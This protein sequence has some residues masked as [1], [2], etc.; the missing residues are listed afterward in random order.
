MVKLQVLRRFAKVFGGSKLSSA[1]R[2]WPQ[3]RHHLCACV[4]VAESCLTLWNPMNSSPPGSSVFGISQA[5]ILECVANPFSRGSSRPRDWT[6]VSCIAGRVFTVWATREAPT[7]PLLPHNNPHKTKPF[8]MPSY[9]K[10]D[11]SS[12]PPW[13]FR[14]LSPKQEGKPTGAVAFHCTG[15]ICRPNWVTNYRK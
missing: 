9:S 3:R 7:A 1:L 12:F 2:S 14:K 11:T 4:K 13:V 8:L 15:G 6:W 10:Q 5:R